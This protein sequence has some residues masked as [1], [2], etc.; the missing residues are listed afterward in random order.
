MSINEIFITL[1]LSILFISSLIG[2]SLF[3]T[4]FAIDYELKNEYSPVLVHLS[5]ADILVG[6][7]CIVPH[8]SMNVLNHQPHSDLMC[9]IFK[10]SH[11]LTC[12]V[13]V[14]IFVVLSTEQLNKIIQSESNI[15]CLSTRNLSIGLLI[16]WIT[17]IISS[18][19]I[20]I[21]S[22]KEFFLIDG[23]NLTKCILKIDLSTAKLYDIYYLY[24]CFVIPI[25]IMLFNI[26]FISINLFSRI[27]N[28][29][30]SR[31]CYDNCKSFKTMITLSVTYI[32]LTFPF[33]FQ[34]MFQH[35]EEKNFSTIATNPEIVTILLYFDSSINPL[36]YAILS[37]RTR[38][39]YKN[40]F[41]KNLYINRSNKS[42]TLDLN[43]I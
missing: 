18:I 19:P 3:I 41:C 22:G 36:I 7:F 10:F 30:S 6:L 17:S 24:L 34:K 11:S 37:K 28:S 13:R 31:T 33:H 8:L 39:F 2:N 27:K 12:T 25:L 40:L 23:F 35:Y 42:E 9:Q 5:V 32:L 4:S 14:F 15:R 29:Q 38:N 20:F 21:N 43:N 26:L 16:I 1:I